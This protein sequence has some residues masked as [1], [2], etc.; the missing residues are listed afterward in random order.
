MLSSSD[1]LRNHFS[2]LEP[3]ST[4]RCGPQWG[5]AKPPHLVRLRAVALARRRGRNRPAW[6]QL[7]TVLGSLGGVTGASG[8]CGTRWDQAGRSRLR[9]LLLPT[10]AATRAGRGFALGGKD[11]GRA[12]VMCW[13]LGSSGLGGPVASPGFAR[14]GALALRLRAGRGVAKNARN[15]RIAGLCRCREGSTTGATVWECQLRC[16]RVIFIYLHIY[17]YIFRQKGRGAPLAPG[18]CCNSHVW[19]KG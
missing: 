13:A 14:L 15:I 12:P 18:L 1:A 6:P 11:V 8:S 9:R 16:S 4:A 17:A 7:R 2:C 3:D 19:P 10:A 5:R